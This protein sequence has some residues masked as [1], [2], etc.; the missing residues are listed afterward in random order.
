MLWLGTFL[1]I[2]KFLTA[3]FINTNSSK[4]AIPD[5]IRNDID[6]QTVD[7]QNLQIGSN[8]INKNRVISVSIAEVNSNNKSPISSKIKRTSFTLES[9]ENHNEISITNNDLNEEIGNPEEKEHD[10]GIGLPYYNVL[11]KKYQFKKP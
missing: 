10:Y 6:N 2:V 3:L 11:V 1:S 8:K 9:A 5:A 7:A 4:I